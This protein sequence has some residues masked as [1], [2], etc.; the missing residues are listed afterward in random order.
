MQFQVPL[1]CTHTLIMFLM[2]IC[3]FLRSSFPSIPA[4][5]GLIWINE[6]SGQKDVP[7]ILPWLD[8]WRTSFAI[9]AVTFAIVYHV[10]LQVLEDP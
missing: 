3:K 2:K 1:P 5:L 10:C 4:A 8:L 9:L 7:I 6:L